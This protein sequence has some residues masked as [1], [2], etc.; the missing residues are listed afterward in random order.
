MRG[1]SIKSSSKA[2]GYIDF[3]G[4]ATTEVPT[5]SILQKSD[6]TEYEALSTATISTQSINITSLTR[7]GATAIA[8]TANN[9]NLATGLEV[10]IA[11]ANQTA[12]NITTS[13]I[14]ISNTQ[15]SFTVA[16][17]PTTPATGTINATAT[18]GRVAVICRTNGTVGN[19]G[20]GSQLE[21]VSP[22]E[23]VDDF[24]IA[25]YEGIFVRFCIA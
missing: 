21:L 13:I 12:Y 1:L 15:F 20:S 11:G 14:V 17:A 8:T 4:T 3:T 16:N 22:I 10:I 19:L 23:D 7:I 18:F 5:G 2:T 9:H 6:G 24:A 25:T